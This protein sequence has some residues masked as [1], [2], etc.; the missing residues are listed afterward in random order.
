MR[1]RRLASFQAASGIWFV[2]VPKHGSWL[3]LL[4][5]CS[6]AERVGFDYRRLAQVTINT[7]LR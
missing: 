5:E 6:Q 7:T 3:N 4:S 2:F 1:S